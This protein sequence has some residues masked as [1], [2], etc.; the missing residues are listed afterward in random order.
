VLADETVEA[1]R[2][3]WDEG[4]NQGDVEVIMAP[5]AD[6]VVFT[7]PFVPMVSGDPA[8]AAIEGAGALRAYVVQALERTPG[9]RY[10]VDATYV[11]FDT[12]VLVYR[13]FLPDGRIK[14]GADS[15]RVDAA[16]KIVDWRSHYATESMTEL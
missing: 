8:Q 10:T 12:L 14:L 5:F 9:I 1:L 2:R 16:G 13:C 6:D 4:W 11:G 15:M 3:H 7:S